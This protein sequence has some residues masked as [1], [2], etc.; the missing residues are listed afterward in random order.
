MKPSISLL[1]P[2]MAGKTREANMGWLVWVWSS[3][4]KEWRRYRA[5][6][7]TYK[8]AS[9]QTRNLSKQM[10][11]P[12]SPL[13]SCKFWRREISWF[14]IVLSTVSF[15]L[16]CTTLCSKR[17]SSKNKISRSTS[18]PN[19]SQKVWLLYSFLRIS[20]G[21]SLCSGTSWSST[22]PR[23]NLRV[24]YGSL[25]NLRTAQKSSFKFSWSRS[26]KWVW[27]FKER[28]KKSSK[29]C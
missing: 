15:M 28:T 29:Y 24:C 17:T 13:K 26:S 2:N 21:S 18:W 5:L 3:L 8:S 4:L 12:N 1:I 11:T 9:L 7:Y 22:T 10:T 16:K 27:T 23:Q 20:R 14:R 19:S 25:Y 6:S